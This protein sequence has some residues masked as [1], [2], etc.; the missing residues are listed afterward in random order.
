M[1]LKFLVSVDYL[2]YIWPPQRP[3]ILGKLRDLLQFLN[4]KI[5]YTL[6]KFKITIYL[7]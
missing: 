2:M 1:F 3:A 5:E 6:L 4:N 7:F